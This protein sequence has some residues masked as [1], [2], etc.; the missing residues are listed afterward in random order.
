MK[1]ETGGFS[2]LIRTLQTYSFDVVTGSLA[3]GLFAVKWCDVR[4]PEAW[5][6]VLAMAVWIIYTSDHII[7]S[8]TKQGS[9]LIYR[10][11]VHFIF[12]NRLVFAGVFLSMATVALSILYLDR[13]TLLWGVV[14]GLVVILYLSGIAISRKK[15]KYFLKEFFIALI[16]VAG[17]WLSPLVNAVNLPVFSTVALL[18]V[19]VLLVLAE[20]L[21]VSVYEVELDRGDN[22]Q[23]F[24]TRF[25]TKKALNLSFVVLAAAFVISLYFVFYFGKSH[26]KYFF[27]S[28]L[29]M[30]ILL[31]ALLFF[32]KYFKNGRRYRILGETVFWL[33]A[34]IAFV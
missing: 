14:L 8:Y 4:L 18:S 34:L 11:K 9:A 6:F 20:G 30:D 23:S 1:N 10:H 21:I 12:K 22:Q 13:K 27:V 33:P 3:T 26:K 15:D 29:L 19:F 16:Y 24:S 2:G 7:D 32:Q 31:A 28:T 25:G 5:W 17:I